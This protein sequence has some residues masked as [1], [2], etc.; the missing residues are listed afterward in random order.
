MGI[1]Y[2]RKNLLKKEKEFSGF[3]TRAPLYFA[4]LLMLSSIEKEC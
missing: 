2:S 4:L 3:L 1:L